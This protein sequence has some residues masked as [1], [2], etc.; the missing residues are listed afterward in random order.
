[1]TLPTAVTAYLAAYQE[2]HGHL[3]PG[4]RAPTLPGDPME[5]DDTPR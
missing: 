3:P 2:R 4:V 5:A 1:L